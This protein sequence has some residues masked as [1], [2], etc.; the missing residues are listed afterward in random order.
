MLAI[1][2][3]AGAGAARVAAIKLLPFLLVVSAVLLGR[4]HYQIHVKQQGTAWTRRIVWMATVL[5][6]GMWL[7][8][9]W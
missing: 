5:V 2:G 8:R 9:L 4:A 1:L 3:L 6:V 7:P